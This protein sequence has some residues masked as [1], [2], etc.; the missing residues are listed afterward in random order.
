MPRPKIT[1]MIRKIPI[2]NP[3]EEELSSIFDLGNVSS[4]CL[5][6]RFSEHI[7]IF[8][9]WLESRAKQALA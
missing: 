9:H 7:I 2:P 4:D 3:M 5:L 6:H 1:T 8:I